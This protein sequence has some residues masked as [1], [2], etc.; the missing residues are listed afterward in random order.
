MS[1]AKSVLK[2]DENELETICSGEECYLRSLKTWKK[3]EAENYLKYERN[4]IIF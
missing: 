2:F 1:L 4:H 3:S